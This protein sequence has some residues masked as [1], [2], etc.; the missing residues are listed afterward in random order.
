MKKYLKKYK[1]FE[2]LGNSVSEFIN[3][4]Y[5]LRS[6]LDL[7]EPKAYNNSR[8]MMGLRCEMR[9]RISSQS[10]SYFSD[11]VSAAKGIKQQMER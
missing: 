5:R 1:N 9:E 10:F 2:Q 6:Y 8:Y 7:N 11:L 4:F 3:E